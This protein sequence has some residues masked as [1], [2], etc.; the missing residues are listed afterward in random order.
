MI[1]VKD[2]RKVFG[3]IVAVDGVS[4]KAAKGDVL[5]LLGPNGAGKSTTMRILSCFLPPDSGTAV[6]AGHDIVEDPIAVQRNIGY[7]AEN[8]PAYDEM[9][10]DSFLNFVCE[11]RGMHRVERREAVNHIASVTAIQSV[12]RQPIGTLSKGYRRRVG[13][14]QALIHNPPVLIL[15]EPTDGLDPN[16]KHDVRMLIKKLAADKCIIISTHILEEVDAICNRMAIID[17]GRLLIDS[18]P[19]ELRAREGGSLDEIFRKLTSHKPAV[20]AA[21]GAI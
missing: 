4:F 3:P 21:G 12:M 7:L 20:A 16:Q 10:A 1:E 11:T 5:G 9:T 2:L 18:T 8:A 15:D 19:N 17:R 14:A 6:I 13:L